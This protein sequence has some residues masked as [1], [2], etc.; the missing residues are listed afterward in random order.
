MSDAGWPA[1]ST[2][3]SLDLSRSALVLIDMQ[4][5]Y[6]D[7]H[8]VRGSWIRMHHPQVYEYFFDRIES[9][10]PKLTTMLERFRELA[11]PV[12]HVT[13]G[14][15]RTDRADMSQVAHRSPPEWAATEEQAEAFLV[16]G[17]EHR[18][19][20][21]LTPLPNEFVFNKTSHSAFTS[22]PIDLV[23]RSLGVTQLVVAGWA[24]DACV[25]LTAR[26]AADRGFETFLVEDGCAAFSEESHQASIEN[27]GRLYGAVISVDALTTQ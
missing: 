23:L 14:S 5:G 10:I 6:T 19:V 18:I 21:A 4:R 7:R 3:F 25:G 11:L 9:V 22:T 2:G 17:T 12:V 1:T 15:S 26:D 13:F 27:F 24:T 8:N 20:S 16:G